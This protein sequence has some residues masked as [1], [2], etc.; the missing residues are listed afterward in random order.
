ML[1]IKKLLTMLDLQDKMNSVVNPDWRNAG[2]HWERAIM[3]EAVEALDHHGWK[4]WKSSTPDMPQVRMELVDIWHFALSLLMVQDSDRDNVALADDLSHACA[5]PTSFPPGVTLLDYLQEMVKLSAGGEFCLDTFAACLHGTG[6]T[7]D[8]LYSSYVG[9]NT[10]NL[11]RQKFGYKTG[12]YIKDWTVVPLKGESLGRALEDNDHLHEILLEID[13]S[14]DN[15]Q[16]VIM[17]E[18]GVRY[19]ALLA[20]SK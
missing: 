13:L 1:T 18:L 7:W 17:S 9:K 8:D 20:H 15:L 10:L 5:Q 11:F 16:D 3:V 2:Y 14:A 4:W 19:T 6:M 12:E